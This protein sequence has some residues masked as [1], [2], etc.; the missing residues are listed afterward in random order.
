MATFI[1]A[2]QIPPSTTVLCA[3]AV[4]FATTFFVSSAA[5]AAAPT[6]KSRFA[7][8]PS[9]GN[10]PDRTYDYFPP[11]ESGGVVVVQSHPWS[12]RIPD[13]LLV[14]GLVKGVI[15]AGHATFVLRHR[16]GARAVLD[17][18]PSAPRRTVAD[19]TFKE[20]QALYE[21]V[22]AERERRGVTLWSRP[23]RDRDR[24]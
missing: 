17:D 24:P 18:L 6:P 8:D 3:F 16:D 12:E 5:P 1:T 4:I 23:G 13:E 19:F 20:A 15:R 14:S 21:M 9:A 22:V 11:K 10:D 2:R 7:Y